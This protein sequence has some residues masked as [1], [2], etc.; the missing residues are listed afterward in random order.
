M[1]PYILALVIG[2]GSLAFYMAAF[3]LPEIHR[4]NDFIWSG[5]GL[6]YALIL[7]VCGERITGAVLLGQMASVSLLGWL[8]WQTLTMRL[9]L[10]S[11]DKR[12]EISPEILEKIKNLSIGGFGQQLLQPITNLLGKKPAK[13][14]PAPTAV[15][16]TVTPPVAEVSGEARMPKGE[17][18]RAVEAETISASVDK[19]PETISASVDWETETISATVDEKPKTIPTAQETETISATVEEKPETIPTAI[20]SETETISATVEEETGIR[21][22]D[23]I[24]AIAE[25]QTIPSPIQDNLPTTESETTQA[26]EETSKETVSPDEHPATVKSSTDEFGDYGEAEAIAPPSEAVVAEKPETTPAPTQEKS[27][28]IKQV[29]GLFK[30]FFSKQ[31][32]GETAQTKKGTDSQTT[33]PERAIALFDE[34]P[35]A[36]EVTAKETQSP[37]PPPSAEVS[38]EISVAPEEVTPVE[39]QT[40]EVTESPASSATSEVSWETIPISEEVTPVESQTP[41]VTESPTPPTTQPLPEETS[42][43]AEEA[44]SL[45]SVS[46]EVAESL[47]PHPPVASPWDTLITEDKENEATPEAETSVSNPAEEDTASSDSPKIIFRNRPNS[48]LIEVLKT[49]TSSDSSESSNETTKS[50]QENSD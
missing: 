43:M 29:S 36:D 27:S 20:A 22:G 14:P 49:P 17:L 16:A 38:R 15:T 35:D 9:E 41:A 34:S 7:W 37:A 6:F 8:G 5:I 44:A 2:F 50:P 3:F 42:V 13:T 31:R 32:S 10:T 21:P 45:D 23:I 46:A 48:K 33:L 30:N 28:P 40:P 39:S 47:P 19:E 25:S 11:P 12:T 4:K 24:T 26:T 18:E 1:L